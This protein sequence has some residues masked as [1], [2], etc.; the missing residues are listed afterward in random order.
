MSKIDFLL[1]KNDNIELI[2]NQ[3]AG[4]LKIETE[5]QYS[6]AVKQGAADSRDYKIGVFVER[7]RPWELTGNSE[8][9]NPFPLINVSLSGYN[10]EAG[11]AQSEKKYKATF[12]IDCY[13]CGNLNNT[14]GDDDSL[15]TIR[16]WKTARIARNILMSSYYTY[17]GLR[18]TVFKRGIL[19]IQTG[20]PS[21]MPE[22]AVAV[23]TCRISFVVDFSEK[24]PQEGGVLF[25][26][27]AF[28][29]VSE[30]GEILI[31]I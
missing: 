20:N 25:E 13:G 5:N 9:K 26:G 27:M 31:D 19:S 6:L 28:R 30:N 16:A 11:S 23:I 17:L 18:G 4:I 15:A 1:A 29:A 24:S 7:A 14:S 22:S 3:I 10:G 2:R 8:N 12:Y 21:N